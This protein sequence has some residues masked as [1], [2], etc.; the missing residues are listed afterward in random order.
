MKKALYST[1]LFSLVLASA[2]STEAWYSGS[3]ASHNISCLQE[4]KSD[5]EACKNE[6]PHSHDEYMEA[7]EKLKTTAE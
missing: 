6:N 3:K 1:L 7:R 4:S 5:Y 2:C